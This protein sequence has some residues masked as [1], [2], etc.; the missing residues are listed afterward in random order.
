MLLPN[1]VSTEMVAHR[2]KPST[3]CWRTCIGNGS[4]SRG[5]RRSSRRNV[6]HVRHGAGYAYWPGPRPGQICA[7]VV[8]VLPVGD[9]RIDP[10]V[11]LPKCLIHVRRP[12]HEQ[13][14]VVH[15]RRELVVVW[16]AAP[17][18]MHPTV[19][20]PLHRD[21]QLVQRDGVQ[22]T[23]ITKSAQQAVAS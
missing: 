20:G 8:C 14:I 5:G 4:S 12:R 9:A 19:D 18:H 7:I 11:Q 13:P 1:R 22:K 2:S 21:P 3:M 17:A 23:W 6:R 15:I 16:R 10:S